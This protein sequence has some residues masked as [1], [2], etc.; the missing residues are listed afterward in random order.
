MSFFVT[1]PDAPVPSRREISMPCSAAIFRT[2]GL[3]RVRRNSSAVRAPCVPSAGGAPAV[4]W[5]AP[6]TSVTDVPPTF[7][8]G[9]VGCPTEGAAARCCGALDGCCGGDGGCGGAGAAA[10]CCGAL[11]GCCGGDGGC[12]GAGAAA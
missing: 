5:G 9:V 12:G 11:D 8:A 7:G 10:R 6:E 2:R 1:R 4:A 3:E